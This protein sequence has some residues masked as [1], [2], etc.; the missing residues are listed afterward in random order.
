MKKNFV[1]LVIKVPTSDIFTCVFVSSYTEIPKSPI[2][3]T[4]LFTK[5]FSNLTSL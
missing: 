2:L 4:P 1:T 5:K 3:I